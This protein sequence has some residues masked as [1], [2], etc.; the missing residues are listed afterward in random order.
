[1]NLISARIRRRCATSAD[2]RRDRLADRE[3]L[4]G[5]PFLREVAAGRDDDLVPAGRVGGRT[6]R[7]PD[8][9]RGGHARRHHGGRAGVAPQH[10]RAAVAVVHRPRVVLDVDDQHVVRQRF[11]P[12]RPQLVQLHGEARS[13]PRR[14]RR[15]GA[16]MPSSAAT[17]Q[18]S[19]GIEYCGEQ[20]PAIT[21]PM[22]EG[23]RPARSIAA[24]RPQARPS[25]RWCVTRTPPHPPGGRSSCADVLERQHGAAGADARRAP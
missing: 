8:P 11:W 10:G 4:H 13:R 7:V 1:M 14:R 19:A 23:V 25:A 20:P 2:D 5:G 6:S 9:D 21:R 15:P 24:M 18:A 22:S 17:R 16:W 3:A 12:H